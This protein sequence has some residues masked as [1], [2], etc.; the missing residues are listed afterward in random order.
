MIRKAKA[1]LARHRSRWSG[2]LSTDSGVLAKNALFLQNPLREREGHNPEEL[3]A[4]AHAG[5]LHM[6]LA[7]GVANCRIYTPELSTE[8]SIYP[9]LE[10]QGFRISRS[11]L[12][13]APL[14][15]HR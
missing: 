14:C 4:A 8:A 13:C 5:L 15:K 1:M 10:G 3:I 12:S 11:S 6:A 9:H 2:N 7:F